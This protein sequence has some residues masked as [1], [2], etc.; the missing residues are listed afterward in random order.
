MSDTLEIKSASGRSALEIAAWQT[1]DPARRFDYL[2]ITLTATGLRASTRVYNIE[3]TGGASNLPAFLEDMA[4]N[5]RGWRGEKRWASI[6]GDLKLICTSSTLG[7]ITIV[8]ELDSYVDDP[9]IWDV[10]CSIV[11]ESWQLDALAG[12]AKRFFRYE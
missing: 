12:Q 4:S 9:Y 3:H 11:L 6:E 2:D 1:T 5:W 8:V 10:R 7:H